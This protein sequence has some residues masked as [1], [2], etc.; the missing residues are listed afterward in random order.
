MTDKYE[1]SVA[2]AMRTETS[3][4]PNALR[5]SSLR[6]L[7]KVA[8]VLETSSGFGRQMLCGIARYAQLNGPW[9]FHISACDDERAVPQAKTWDATGI[10][11]RIPN[12]QV[13]S[14]IIE[15]NVPT[16]A[17]GMPDDQ[18]RFSNPQAPFSELSSD[19]SAVAKMAA[20][21]L[22]ERRFRN[23]AYIGLEGRAWSRRRELAYCKYL[24]GLGWHV[25]VYPQ[26]PQKMDRCWESEQAIMAAWIRDLPKPV[27][28][29]ACDDDRARQALDACSLA[30][31][32]VPEDVAVLG[33][34][35]DD[36]F[37]ALANPPLSS[38]ALNAEATGF[39]AA[40]L[41]DAMM[42]GSVENPRRILLEPQCVHTRRSTDIAA[43]D[44]EDVAAAIQ[45]IR[46]AQG[47]YISVADVVD[48][49]AVSRRDLEKRFR[50][51]LGRT[52]HEEIQTARLN[53]AK[54]LLLETNYP[55]HYIAQISGFGSESYFVNCFRRRVGKTPGKFRLAMATSA[56]GEIARPS[57]PRARRRA[58][59]RG[60]A[61]AGLLAYPQLRAE[62]GQQ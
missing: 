14:A 37:C 46:E 42:R 36:V 26:P 56:P 11:A 54:R 53:C 28:L 6:Q 41:L 62:C 17:F 13:A 38:V 1:I 45:Y 44:D 7:P 51:M 50:I 40:E 24:V 52:I 30:G 5:H 4:K 33:V 3:V 10:I 58:R 60:A 9:S 18:M 32:R 31:L 16:I 55:L 29:F 12:D 25:H 27:G 2:G 61:F 57:H 49:V 48:E 15:A 20:D 39:R 34:D 59:P 21:H 23:F 22:L 8:L 47:A 19:S 43:V 35:D